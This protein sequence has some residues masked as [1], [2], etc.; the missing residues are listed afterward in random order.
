MRAVAYTRC[1]TPGQATE[2]VSLQNQTER[3]RA[4]AKYK[5]LT[6]VE[7]IEDA[8]FSGGKNK[9]R[10]GF[11][12]LLD[13]VQ[14]GDIDVIILYSLDRI[15]RDALTTLAL[16]RLLD[17]FNVELHTVEGAI[18]TSTP[19][20]WLN[21]AVKSL[22]SEHERRQIRYRTR[23]SL[24]YKKSNGQV[25]GSVPYGYRREEKELV[26]VEEEQEIIRIANELYQ[27]G[28]RLVDITGHLNR[29]GH[30]TRTGKSWSPMQVKRLL[31]GYEDTF[32]KGT[33]RIA[34]AS[35]KFIEAIA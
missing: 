32:R 19:D 7:E 22:L 2:G 1:S 31:N 18:D 34:E 27:N 13:R 17:E 20:G 9:A 3:I 11:I 16:E 33:S 30:T 24:E 8:G 15:S 4:Y 10:V 26:P 5:G 14:R 35:R 12:A 25:V 23:K 21:F 28:A 6:I 29:K